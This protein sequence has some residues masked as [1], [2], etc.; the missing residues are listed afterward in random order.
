[1]SISTI[2][3]QRFDFIFEDAIRLHEL[4]QTCHA[5]FI[6]DFNDPLSLLTAT[7][8]APNELREKFKF[9][10]HLSEKAQSEL[11]TIAKNT[12]K[13]YKLKFEISPSELYSYLKES[14][15]IYL[16]NSQP[17]VINRKSYDK[18]VNL[19]LRKYRN[20][21]REIIYYYPAYFPLIKNRF[22]LGIVSIL[23]I[24]DV[25]NDIQDSD[26][27]E[28][29]KKIKSQFEDSFNC[30]VSIP[31]GKSSS[32]ISKNRALAA[33]HLASGIIELFLFTYKTSNFNFYIND[34]P[35]LSTKN[36]HV[37]QYI[38]ENKY[39]TNMQSKFQI[40][41]DFFENLENDLNSPLGNSLKQSIE[42]ACNPVHKERLVD[43]L[44][45]AICW[46]GD[47]RKEQNIHAQVVKIVTSLE[48]LASF[49]SEKDSSQISE[50]FASRI[51][52]LIGLY[53][54]QNELWYKRVK[55]LYQLRSGLVHGSYSLYRSYNTELD[56]N[57][58]ELASYAIF[59]ACIVFF[60]LGFELENYEDKLAEFYKNLATRMN[61]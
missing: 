11:L 44:I 42:F 12:I 49:E 3:S 60:Q 15:Y 58:V 54:H 25:E 9:Q 55:K 10:I 23:P 16:A 4:I 13:S 19:A 6:D 53:H 40:I 28:F 59:S 26:N 32:N 22:N 36:F 34:T 48:R 8:N 7:I 46:F 31:I 50:N 37:K 29:Y 1:M 24:A 27:Y 5:D 47:A 33:S 43:R 45:D 41:G 39:D 20:S 56:F 21:C 51:S 61:T 17:E 2:D 18:I 14:I 35:K 38:P 52:S 57:A 30:Y